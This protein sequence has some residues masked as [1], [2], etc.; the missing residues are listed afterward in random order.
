LLRR[1]KEKG[2]KF[3]VLEAGY[4]AVQ[5]NVEGEKNELAK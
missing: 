2:G 4:I 3:S 5:R 1:E